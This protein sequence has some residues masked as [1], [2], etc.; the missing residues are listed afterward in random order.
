MK[1][2]DWKF[3]TVISGIVGSNHDWWFWCGSVVVLAGG[4]DLWSF[5]SWFYTNMIHVLPECNCTAL[6][7]TIASSVLFIAFTLPLHCLLHS[8]HIA[9]FI[10]INHLPQLLYTQPIAQPIAQPKG[11]YFPHYMDHQLSHCTHSPH[12][13]L[14]CKRAVLSHTVRQQ[15]LD[16][17]RQLNLLQIVDHVH[18]WCCQL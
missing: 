7:F 6:H 16:D 3:L 17:D 10:A 14:H 2:T 1:V 4:V 15:W 9:S 11:C 8:L 5:S 18:L 13:W 12:H